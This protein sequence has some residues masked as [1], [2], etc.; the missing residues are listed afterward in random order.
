MTAREQERIERDGGHR[1]GYEADEGLSWL[2]YH[3]RF[4]EWN[5]AGAQAIELIAQ[6]A[7][8][9]SDEPYIHT[10]PRSLLAGRHDKY[11]DRPEPQTRKRDVAHAADKHRGDR[12]VEAVGR[13]E[14]HNKMK[15]SSTQALV[16]N[17]SVTSCMLLVTE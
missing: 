6:Q 17:Y 9:V 12:A 11:A 2:E 16:D 1:R 8:G 7:E 5:R 14:S 10:D 15:A 13:R 3:R 4:E